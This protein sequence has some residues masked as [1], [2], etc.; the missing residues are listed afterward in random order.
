[1]A[2]QLDNSSMW[3]I[4]THMLPEGRRAAGTTSTHVALRLQ[5]CRDC[6]STPRS[7]DRPI[8]VRPSIEDTDTNSPGF[9]TIVVDIV[10]CGHIMAAH[11]NFRFMHRLF[12]EVPER[13][14][15]Q[16]AYVCKMTCLKVAPGSALAA[17]MADDSSI[18]HVYDKAPH[19]IPRAG[20]GYI[21]IA[22]CHTPTAEDTG[23]QNRSDA[24]SGSID[25]PAAV[26]KSSIAIGFPIWVPAGPDLPPRA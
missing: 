5:G 16:V 23:I 12:A 14:C 22:G 7:L 1:M 19:R 11:M 15:P 18:L 2:R 25:S 4:N 9:G 20:L 10:M 24:A 13:N 8:D 6:R 17:L 26:A 3:H 21:V